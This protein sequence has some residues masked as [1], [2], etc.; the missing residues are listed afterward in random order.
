MHTYAARVQSE[1]LAGTQIVV[2]VDALE[3]LA[4]LE[5]LERE[6]CDQRPTLMFA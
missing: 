4:V 2:F 6:S 1:D 3:I 5:E